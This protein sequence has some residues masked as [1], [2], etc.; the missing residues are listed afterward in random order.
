[1]EVPKLGVELELQLQAYAT[2]TATTDP[3]CIFDLHHSSWPRQI[4]SP[5]RKARDQ[6]LILM[7]PSQVVSIE[8]QWKLPAFHVFN[9]KHVI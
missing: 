1:M 3:S 9:A 5:L 2:V 4:L 7:N 6:T 8:P